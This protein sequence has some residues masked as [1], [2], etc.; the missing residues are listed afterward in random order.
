MYVCLHMY[1]FIYIYQHKK[2]IL[3]LARMYQHSIF[4]NFI[5]FQNFPYLFS[6]QLAWLLTRGAESGPSCVYKME[7]N[8]LGKTFKCYFFPQRESLP[9]PYLP[10]PSSPTAPPARTV[11]ADNE[12]SHQ[13]FLSPKEPRRRNTM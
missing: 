11:E 5:T 8:F 4:V 9:P 6:R 7:K 3:L 13:H 2:I 12:S 1:E 10:P